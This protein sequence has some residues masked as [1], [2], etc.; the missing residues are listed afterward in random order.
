[1]VYVNVKTLIQLCKTLN[2]KEGM[3]KYSLS[4]SKIYIHPIRYETE[5][6]IFSA[7]HKTYIVLIN[8]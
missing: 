8:L 2:L 3:D 6:T 7:V 4:E 5:D 1:M